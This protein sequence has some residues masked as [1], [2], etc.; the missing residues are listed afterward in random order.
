MTKCIEENREF[1]KLLSQSKTHKRRK[2]ITKATKG[3]INALSELALNTLLGNVPFDSTHKKKLKRHRFSI[4]HL[5][6]KISLKKKKEFLVQ[7]GG[8]LPLLIT[9]ILSILG[10]LAANAISHIS[11]L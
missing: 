2:I 11:G 5:A 4:R 1:L 3:N 6:K 8:F 7:K 9:P 10:G